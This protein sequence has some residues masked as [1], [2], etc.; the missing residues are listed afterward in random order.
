MSI[1]YEGHSSA[2]RERPKPR[3]SEGEHN[4]F[5][6]CHTRSSSTPSRI[7]IGRAALE[8]YISRCGRVHTPM[9]RRPSA[10][11][12]TNKK[13]NRNL[14]PHVCNLCRIVAHHM[15]EAPRP[16]IYASKRDNSCC[17]RDRLSKTSKINLLKLDTSARS[18]SMYVCTYVMCANLTIECANYYLSASLYSWVAIHWV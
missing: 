9:C 17:C 10:M 11:V 12:E 15:Y 16:R 8:T 3:G 6:A 5:V 18:T 1:N 7:N 4:P 13:K 14:Y 2:H